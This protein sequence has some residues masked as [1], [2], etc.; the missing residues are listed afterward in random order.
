MMRPGFSGQFARSVCLW[1]CLVI[2]LALMAGGCQSKTAPLSKN[3]E[4]LKQQLLSEMNTLTAALVAPVAKQ[5]WQA[6]ES[7]LPAKMAELKKR[8]DVTPAN[9]VVLDKNAISQA[10]FPAGEAHQGLD[11]MNYQPAQL[12]FTEK[13]KTRA[14][15]FRGDKK[16]Y[17]CIAPILQQDQVIGAVAMGFPEEDLK[18]WKVSEQEFLNIDFNQ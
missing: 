12:V 4:A 18:I 10:R 1:A 7:I 8:G 5:D 9:I 14:Q 3:A 17:V 16:I 11:F 6:V 2:M 15:L 13:K